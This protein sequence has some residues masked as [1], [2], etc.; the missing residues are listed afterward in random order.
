MPIYIGESNDR[1]RNVIVDWFTL[2]LVNRDAPCDNH[3]HS[4]DNGPILGWYVIQWLNSIHA[5]QGRRASLASL[6]ESPLRRSASS[7]VGDRVCRRI[8]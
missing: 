4:R 3:N 8:S 6:A 2:L 7:V 1:L 5:Y